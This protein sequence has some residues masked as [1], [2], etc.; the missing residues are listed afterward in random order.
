MVI[1]RIRDHVATHNWFAVGVDLA[2][3]IL[4]VF[5]GT[6]ANNW[7]QTRIERAAASDSRREIIDDLRGN[8]LDLASRAAYYRSARNH[9]VAALGAMERPNAPRAE[10]FILDAYQASQVW[11]RPLV[12]TGYD[13]MT[14]AG[15]TRHIGDR[16]T[17]LRLTSYYTNT[18]QFEITALGTTAY[19]E[20]LRRVMP[21]KVQMAINR[22]CGDRVTYLADGSQIGALPD[23]CDLVLDEAMVATTLSQLQAT[24]L[25]E[26]LTRHIA[27][28]DQKLAGF[29]RFGRLAHDLRLR[30][31][32]IEDR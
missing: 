14:G 5:I 26:D 25:S 19:R 8:E 15:L 12:R 28:T 21:Y 29:E 24:D 2:I 3:V 31:E 10:P 1:R 27:D 11:L 22:Q 32:S 17:R 13:E 9:A 7:N 23:R 4:G 30:L 20:R 18:R 6:Q 16:K